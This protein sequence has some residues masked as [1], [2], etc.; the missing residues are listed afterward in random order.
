M[1]RRSYRPEWEA[2]LLDLSRVYTYLAKGKWF[3][4]VSEVG[5]ISIG[6]HIYHLGYDWRPAGYAELTFDPEACE[7]VCRIP[8]GQ[9][10]RLP[11]PWL[12]K[13]ELMGELYQFQ[14]TLPVCP[15]FFQE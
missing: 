9:E 1:P 13:P 5:T 12:T 8:S 2:N 7:F 14:Q 3:R 6:R 10:K 4:K 15:P 11:T